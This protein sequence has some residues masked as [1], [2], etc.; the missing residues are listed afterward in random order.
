MFLFKSYSTQKQDILY[1]LTLNVIFDLR[2]KFFQILS[3][4]KGALS[5]KRIKGNHV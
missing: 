4:H 5:K 1:L 2:N 3:S